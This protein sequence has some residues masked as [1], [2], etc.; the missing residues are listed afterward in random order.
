M[1]ASRSAG[2]ID[3]VLREVEASLGPLPSAAEAPVPQ[4]VAPFV[5]MVVANSRLLAA[6]ALGPLIAM[7]SHFLEILIVVQDGSFITL[8]LPDVI[9]R[10]LST[11]GFGVGK[12]V[13]VEQSRSELI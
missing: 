1:S 13:L 11:T 3:R 2:S 6:A 10:V 12:V 7:G 4:E 5:T 9:R 8:Q